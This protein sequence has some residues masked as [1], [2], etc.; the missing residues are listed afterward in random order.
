MAEDGIAPH[1][2][3][4][5]LIVISGLFALSVSLSN[6]FLNVYLWKVDKSFISI[7]LY[8]LSVYL[9]IPIMFIA[10]G[11]LAKRRN[12][13]LT[14]RL[15]LVFHACFYALTLF[16]G[17]SV[18]QIPQ[19]LGAVLGTAAGFYW[20]GFNELSLRYTDSASRDRFN[21]MNGVVGSVAGML[22]PP[23][24][25]FLISFED[26][27]GGLSGYHL[28]FGLSLAMFMLAGFTSLQL[29][30]KLGH[31]RLHWRNAVDAWKEKGWRYILMGCLVYGWREG[32]F[33]FLIGLLMY[34]ATDS[35][36]E[37]GEFLLLQSG[38]SF[39][40]FFIV[41]RLVHP[42]NRIKFL[43]I[44]AIGMALCA[45]IFLLPLRAV[46]LVWYGAAIATCLPL[47]IVPFQGIIF[48]AIGHLNKVRG[49]DARMEHIITRELFS[50]S[51]RVLG[52]LL[53]L[54]WVQ[55]DPTGQSIPK[56]A[57]GIGFVQLATWWLIRRVR[58]I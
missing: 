42:Q 5:W 53:F 10:A 1:R 28:I 19:L 12:S 52:V 58:R 32:L 37:L 25:G 22:A 11:A 54:A 33:M 40:S 8:N 30:E 18:A 29:H 35:E 21:G 7:G 9:C 44:G 36:L 43:G 41:G 23:V 50:N 56:L 48:D 57:V 31:G 2:S 6:T 34:I 26:R 3:A 49:E 46:N 4:R 13:V 38:L 15:G 39:V 27:F 14:L 24:A 55:L 51:G 47:F 45:L 16:G 20:C 17:Q